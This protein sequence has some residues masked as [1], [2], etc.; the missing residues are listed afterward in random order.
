MG[1]GVFITGT[2]TGVGKTTVAVGLV[3]LLKARGLDV[4]VMK[5]VA[6]GAWHPPEADSRRGQQGNNKVSEDARLLMEAADTN[7]PYELVNPVCLSTPAAPSVAAQEEGVSIELKSIWSA[8]KAL[9]ARHPFLV[10]EGIGGLLVPING[11]LLVADMAKKMSLPL[12]IVARASLGTI[13]HTLLT[14]EAARRRRLKITGV[15]F[16]SPNAPHD[17]KMVDSSKKEIERLS[18]IPVLGVIPYL[19][20]REWPC[21]SQK[22]RDLAVSSA[23]KPL[24]RLFQ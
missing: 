22:D 10:V 8:F 4:G 12:I 5:P 20:R 18:G 21:H 15:I 6:T 1:G 19:F 16:N 13:N 14:V 24:L 17:P 2:D 11:T 3:R 23:L 9:T 7:D